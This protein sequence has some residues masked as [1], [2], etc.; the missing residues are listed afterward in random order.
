MAELNSPKFPKFP[1]RHSLPRHRCLRS[2]S[3]SLFFPL[4]LAD[5]QSPSHPCTSQA[6]AHAVRVSHQ[7][8]LVEAVD[9]LTKPW[10]WDFWSRSAAFCQLVHELM[11]ETLPFSGASSGLPS[12]AKVLQD[13]WPPPALQP[14]RSPLLAKEVGNWTSGT[15]V[16][17]K[18]H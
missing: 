18:I 15:H 7:R 1:S 3:C 14:R 9:F 13:V 8:D 12:A 4:Q 17:G 5:V 10:L 2:Q 6:A 11:S 16:I